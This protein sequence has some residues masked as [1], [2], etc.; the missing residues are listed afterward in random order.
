VIDPKTQAV[1]ATIDAGAPLEAGVVDGKGKLF[2]DGEAKHEIVAIDTA[3]NT[4]T[5]HFA[6][7]GCV[8]PHGIAVDAESRRV[9]ATCANKVMVVVNAEDGTNIAT[10]PIGGYNDGAA[11]DPVRKRALSAN[12]DGTLTV[13]E[14]KD[15]DHFAVAATVATVPSARTIA[16]DPASGRVFL[17]AADVAKIE[18]ASTPGGRPYVTFA[19]GSLRLL[20]FAPTP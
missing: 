2:V 20:V 8:S 10:L 16:I 1:I 4:I 6:M 5:A 9:F 7:P 11:F 14:E 17:P 3:T 19:P 12:G 15:A 18:P 13:V